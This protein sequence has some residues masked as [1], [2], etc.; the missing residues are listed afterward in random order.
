MSVGADKKGNVVKNLSTGEI[1]CYNAYDEVVSYTDAEGKVTKVIYNAQGN[2]T[3][4]MDALGNSTSYT[5]R[6]D[7]LLTEIKDAS[8]AVTLY[9]YNN[10]GLV[11]KETDAL[12]TVTTYEY[13]TENRPV[14]MVTPDGTVTEYIYN[15]DGSVTRVT[16]TKVNG[17]AEEL[18][19]LYNLDG[20]LN[21]SVSSSD[22][23][24]YTYNNRGS[25]AS[26]TKNNNH[27][28]KLTY[29]GNG[30]M[31]RLE[32]L[33]KGVT[34]SVTSYSYDSRGHLSKVSNT[35]GILASYTSRA[36]G[37][38]EQVTDG[39]GNVTKY[40]YDSKKQVTG[41]A[42][43]AADGSVLYSE[44]NTYD[45]NGS[46]LTQSIS[47][48]GYDAESLAYT[49]DA[50][51]RLLSETNK[52][53]TTTYTYDS[54]GNRLTKISGDVTT[55]YTYDLCNKLLS[56]TTG[57]EE[58][59]YSY[60]ALGNLTEKV[61]SAGATTYA[62]DALNQ[63]IKVTN[64]DGTWQSNT[65]DASGIRFMITE[66][67]ITTEF[68]NFNGLVLSGYDKTGEQT[69]HYYYGSSLLAAEYAEKANNTYADLYYYL[70]NSHGDI[71]G[72]TDTY[73]TLTEAYRYDAFGTLTSIQ[74][75]NEN[76]V[77][78]EAETALSRFLYAG[79]QYD[80]VTG[81]YYLRA[82]QY[83]TGIGRFTQED[84]YLGDGRNLYVYVRNNPLK[85]VDPSGHCGK[86]LGYDIDDRVNDLYLEMVDGA[87]PEAYAKYLEEHKEWIAFCDFVEHTTENMAVNAI[88]NFV[89]E[90]VSRYDFASGYINGIWNGVTQLPSDNKS[91]LLNENAYDAGLV[92]GE[93][94]VFVADMGMTIISGIGTGFFGLS[95]V[96]VTSGGGIVL[97][98]GAIA[99]TGACAAAATYYA[100][101]A[102][103][104]A[105]RLSDSIQELLSKNKKVDTKK[106]TYQNGV[107]EAADYHSQ[108]TTGK[109]APAPQDG[110]FALDNSVSVGSNTSR[111]VGLDSNGDF[112][113]L[114]ET[115][116]DLYHGHVRSWND[117]D[118]MQG[119]S[120]AMKNAL[121]DAG[122]VK[123]S[124]GT[125]GKLTDYA[126]SLLGQ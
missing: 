88:N 44:K 24:E 12:G 121:Y 35:E 118:D 5:Y 79:E 113:V 61:S 34:E 111:R 99:A 63:L 49:Y 73:G 54:M 110:Q 95:T 108:K 43:A 8:G 83:D 45:K 96:T 59:T 40:Q 56:E 91:Y 28:V 4:T 72:L 14:K 103:N 86:G 117:T 16:A 27:Q 31:T 122:Y 17:E 21:A 47:G 94:T 52:G 15:T 76:G 22:I 50:L 58:T 55:A 46:L 42:I 112:V 10:K 9:E 85:Y 71:I 114:D 38:L 53:V 100:G 104:D 80:T 93:A 41:L 64:P 7:G 66:N 75:L 39:A 74:S 23:L 115:L 68:I 69:E 101:R 87:D 89:N 33:T 11:S 13:D 29:D 18:C 119:L 106:Y 3:S 124:K 97:S 25:V 67:G 102:K 82:R 51:D 81:L 77:L 126:K 19:Y 62:Y 92:A 90:T 70:T 48:T 109:K 120:Q 20:S 84:T 6:K 60:D 57:E 32:E 65:Y 123:S 78:A 105:S 2:V 36:D 37:L 125:K 26:V 116:D 107:Y 30:N 1:Y 98:P